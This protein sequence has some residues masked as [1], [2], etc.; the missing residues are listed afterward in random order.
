MNSLMVS[1]PK[2]TKIKG[3]LRKNLGIYCN[4]YLET[5]K[6]KEKAG[7]YPP[8]CIVIMNVPLL[9]HPEQHNIPN[10]TLRS[11]SVQH[12]RVILS[13]ASVTSAVERPLT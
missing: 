4:S 8:F 5:V 11:G 1:N 6:C 13:E 12:N 7:F 9:C 3:N 2:K 10:C